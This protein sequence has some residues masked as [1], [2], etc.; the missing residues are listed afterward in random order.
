MAIKRIKKDQ[1]DSGKKVLPKKLA[2]LSEA[3]IDYSIVAHDDVSDELSVELPLVSLRALARKSIELKELKRA[4]KEVARQAALV[5][6]LQKDKALLLALQEATASA[7][8]LMR[9]A[10]RRINAMEKLLG[11]APGA[12][13]P[14]VAA[15]IIAS[16][17]ELAIPRKTRSTGPA[18]STR[19]PK[20]TKKAIKKSAALTIA[21]SAVA[22][23]EGSAATLNALRAA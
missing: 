7:D 21:T 6:E 18:K 11:I 15:P 14:A 5:P 8:S 19:A 4:H 17:D 3:G 12:K 2:F 13:L 10:V 1:F 20:A 16:T 23:P 22:E 9:K